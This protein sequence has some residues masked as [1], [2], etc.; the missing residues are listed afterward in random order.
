MQ[1]RKVLVYCHMT[2]IG[3]GACGGGGWTL[4]MK[5]DGRIVSICWLRPRENELDHSLLLR[6]KA[7]A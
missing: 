5:T 7:K 1:S 3:L 4:V 6:L 2:N